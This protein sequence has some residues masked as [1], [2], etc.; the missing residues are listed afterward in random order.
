ML[1]RLLSEHNW[2]GGD[3]KRKFGKRHQIEK[4]K[5]ERRKNW[6]KERREE[7]EKIGK[8]KTHKWYVSVMKPS[9]Y[10]FHKT[11]GKVYRN[12]TGDNTEWEFPGT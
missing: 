12:E 5:I 3:D 6:K 7:R 2:I 10:S 9:S 11:I 4:E 1:E 8:E